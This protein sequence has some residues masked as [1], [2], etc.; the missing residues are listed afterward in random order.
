MGKKRGYCEASSLSMMYSFERAVL[1]FRPWI[2]LRA[3]VP[4]PFRFRFYFFMMI[5]FIWRDGWFGHSVL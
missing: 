2:F 5:V 4:S 3:R 1:V